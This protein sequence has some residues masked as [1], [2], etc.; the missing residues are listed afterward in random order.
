MT[1]RNEA[2]ATVRA[3]FERN[4]WGR[5]RKMPLLCEHDYAYSECYSAIPGH[6]S[7]EF[8]TICADCGETL[9]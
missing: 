1:E 9:E 8:V 6:W 5:P 4:E 2:L 3:Q 7:P